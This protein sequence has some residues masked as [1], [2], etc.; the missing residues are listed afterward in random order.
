MEVTPV[1]LG[2]LLLEEVEEVPPLL[3]LPL[4]LMEV[5]AAVLVMLMQVQEV[6]ELQDKEM[7]EVIL[8]LVV[9]GV[10]AVEAVKAPLVETERLLEMEE[11]A[12]ILMLPGQPQLVQALI[13]VT[14]LEEAVVEYII[15]L[16][17]IPQ[18]V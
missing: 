5:L 7:M 8:L 10:V 9:L 13:V 15:L 14:T 16:L 1:A 17:E 6:V 4:E 11:R 12:P 18:V 2:P 3:I